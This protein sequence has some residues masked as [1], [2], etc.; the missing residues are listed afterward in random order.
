MKSFPGRGKSKRKGPGAGAC[1]VNARNSKEANEVREVTG[2]QAW[3]V[4]GEAMAGL[5]AKRRH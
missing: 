5:E 3:I 4:R 2:G 1:L